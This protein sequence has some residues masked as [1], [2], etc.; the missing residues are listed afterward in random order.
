M[1]R[2][3]LVWACAA[4]LAE[5]FGV[6]ARETPLVVSPAP[7]VYRKRAQMAL[8][9]AGRAWR[10]AYTS[11]SLAG[12]QAA[13]RAGLGLAVLPAEMVPEDFAVLGAASGL[14]ALDDV[15]IA[16]ITG[17]TAPEPARRLAEHMVRSLG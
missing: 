6:H 5:A 11:T 10:V 3:R 1:W 14:P 7:C 17:Q 16:L 9:M 12:A 2:E 4:R 13:V 8:D 15:E